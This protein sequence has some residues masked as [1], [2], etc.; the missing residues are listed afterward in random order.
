MARKEA[1]KLFTNE[2]ST[3]LFHH[4]EQGPSEGEHSQGQG[5]STHGFSGSG[6]TG[7]ESEQEHHVGHGEQASNLITG[8]LSN[9]VSRGRESFHLR[10]LV[11]G[12]ATMESSVH[13]HT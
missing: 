5:Q 8:G 2:L 4:D 10:L 7:S 6:G 1:F 11:E 9:V 12:K 13:T 3:R